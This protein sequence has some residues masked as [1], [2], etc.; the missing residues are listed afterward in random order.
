[1]LEREKKLAPPLGLSQRGGRF[2]TRYPIIYLDG[3]HWPCASGAKIARRQEEIFVPPGQAR[4]R[5]FSCSLLTSGKSRV[6]PGQA[7]RRRFSCSLLTS[8][9]SRAP[10]GQTQRR[11]Q[12]FLTFLRSGL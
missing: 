1:M 7:R 4:R 9:K 8:G 12:F 10:L 2:F 11:R 5:R 6:P 3:L